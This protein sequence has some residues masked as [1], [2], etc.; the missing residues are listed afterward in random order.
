M[1]YFI[2]SAL[3]IP[4]SYA[5]SPPACKELGDILQSYEV[6]LQRDTIRDCSKDDLYK[7]LTPPGATDQEFLKD[8][9]CSNLAT[10]E[11]ELNQYRMELAVMNG[12][13]KLVETVGNA[14]DGTENKNQNVARANGKTFVV[15]LNTAQSFEALFATTT[16]D[17]KP[18]MQAL[19]EVEDIKLLSQRDLSDRVFELCKNQSKNEDNACNPKVFRPGPEATTEILGL[20]KE[21]DRTKPID[22]E[23][24]SKWQGQL[25]IKRKTPKEGEPDSYSFLEMQRELGGAFEN[26]DN[27]TVMTKSQLQAIEKL[28]D[29]TYDK[30]FSFVEDIS[31]LKDQNK[32]KI[33][34]DKFVLLMGDAQLRQQF[35][36]QSKLSVVW[37]DVGTQ[38]TGLSEDQKAQCDRAK[39]LYTDA[40]ACSQSLANAIKDQSDAGL[41]S[42][43]EQFLSPIKTTTD[44]V[45]LLA[46]QEAICRDELKSNQTVSEACF[47]SFNRDRAA[48]QEKILLLNTVKDKIGSQNTT[49]MK[50]RN[51]ALQ[52]WTDQKCQSIASPMDMCED[53]TVFAQNASLA[54]QDSMNIAVM[55]TSSEAEKSSAMAAAEE[56]CDDDTRGEPTRIEIR[57]CEFFNDTTSDV[58]E[59]DNNKDKT[60][61]N[62]KP[63]GN[64][65]SAT[66]DA[67]LQAGSDFLKDVL[68]MFMPKTTPTGVNPYPYN[69]NPYK[70]GTPPMGIADT[71]MFNARYHG[72]YGFYMPT[73]GYQPYTAFGASSPMSSYKPMSAPSTKYFSY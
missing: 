62:L 41:K 64:G 25:A 46:S 3:F 66:K 36:V 30:S 63:A 6:Q 5:G 19:R 22:I 34:S 21:G 47:N 70:G 33:A 71:I 55:F 20:I 69:Y 15:S 17:G 4:L 35:E 51:L 53:T 72:A 12:L 52:K 1:K 26:I 11:A 40:V 54:I 57:L 37:Q 56:V 7:R 10:I 49:A 14:K 67:W 16:A 48:L 45:E 38:V 32:K 18:F 13:H 50:F 68:P 60:G 65:R 39:A 8:K 27:K 61:I 24:I 28:D 59:T 73:P 43:L 42:K 31:L 9:I 44:Y 23:K 2:L 29:F 58:I